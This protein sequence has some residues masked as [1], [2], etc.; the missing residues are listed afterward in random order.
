[1][2]SKLISDNFSKGSKNYAKYAQ[3]QKDCAKKLCKFAFKELDNAK[4]ILD[5]GS[6]TGNLYDNCQNL[7]VDYF[8]LDI[9]QKML[10]LSRCKNKINASFEE[11][12]VK[13]NSFDLIL[14]S[15]ALQWSFNYEKI[16]SEINRI[17]KNNSYLIICAPVTGTLK[18]LKDANKESESNFYIINFF[19]DI[20][21]QNKSKKFN[22][23][24]EN[25]KSQKIS[26]KYENAIDAIKKMKLIGA[27]YNDKSNN[28]IN[29]KKV[30]K[31]NDIFQE[32][33]NN[34]AS[35]NVNYMKFKKC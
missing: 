16:L 4:N 27:N 22:L 3:I 31:F 8:E 18:E 24:L 20:K 34:I 15:F 19:D 2:D 30:K 29:R 35:W 25:S 5:L 12:P 32:K 11:V 6:G 14:S 9:S 7:K 10:D 33:Y 1:M 13:D 23:K 21:F 17:L 26:V 28:V